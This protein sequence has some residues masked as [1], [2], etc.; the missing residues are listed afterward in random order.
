M[1]DRITIDELK[2]F[3]GTGL[4]IHGHKEICSI[5]E[6]SLKSDGLEYEF[7]CEY[8]SENKAIDLCVNK[9][10]V[11]PVKNITIEYLKKV[12]PYYY[13]DIEGDKNE[14]SAIRSVAYNAKHKF[15]EL[16]EANYLAR[17]HFDIFNWLNRTGP[18]GKPLAIE[19]E[20]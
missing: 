18:D 6:C 10:I 8:H 15:L 19:M 2:V 3:V 17:G 11:Q 12:D 14:R 1:G 20:G 16:K 13:G 4:E 9:P 7:R 5:N